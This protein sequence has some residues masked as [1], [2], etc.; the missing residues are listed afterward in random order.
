MVTQDLSPSGIAEDCDEYLSGQGK[1]GSLGLVP[2][3]KIKKK[4]KKK[5]KT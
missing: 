3:K 1:T 2:T 5:E 4:N